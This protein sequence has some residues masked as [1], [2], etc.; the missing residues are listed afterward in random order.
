MLL[1]VPA[2]S[3]LNAA[4]VYRARQIGWYARGHKARLVEPFIG[5]LIHL[6]SSQIKTQTNLC[7]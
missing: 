4:A 7:S 1:S 3:C 2:T 5:R 6:G